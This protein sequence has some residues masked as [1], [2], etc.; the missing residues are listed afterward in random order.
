M[1]PFMSPGESHTRKKTVKFGIFYYEVEHSRGLDFIS[2][3]FIECVL[4]R[5]FY[6]R[7]LV[8]LLFETC[9]VFKYRFGVC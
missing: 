2:E 9:S 3:P 8:K 7:G 4:C 1:T 6:V 5:I